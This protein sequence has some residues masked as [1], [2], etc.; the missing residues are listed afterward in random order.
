MTL[1]RSTGA[2]SAASA[3]FGSR[4]RQQAVDDARGAERLLFDLLE[5]LGAGIVGVGLLEQHL[6]IS[7]KCR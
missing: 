2:R 5:H 6:R 1:L 4:Q 3:A 7:S